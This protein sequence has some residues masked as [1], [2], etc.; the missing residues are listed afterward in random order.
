MTGY[1]RVVLMSSTTQVSPDVVKD[2]AFAVYGG[3][4]GADCRSFPVWIQGIRAAVLV[5]LDVN[6][7]GRRAAAGLGAIASP[8][9]LRLLLGLPLGEPVPYAALT[10]AERSALRAVPQ[11][12]VSFGDSC[13][14]RQVVPPLEVTLALV[15]AGS[16]RRGLERAGRFAPFCP[17]AM[18]LRVPPRDLDDLY[19][20]TGFYGVGV[21]VAGNDAAPEILVEPARFHRKRFTVAGWRFL[22]EVYRQVSSSAELRAGVRWPPARHPAA[23]GL[24]IAGAPRGA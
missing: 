9:V 4:G 8:D 17:R 11:A 21:I 3:W 14:I 24:P 15:P 19:M 18:V 7:C 22:E 10:G 13:V 23:E 6:E 20:E 12:A 2:V 16:W 1:E 5:R